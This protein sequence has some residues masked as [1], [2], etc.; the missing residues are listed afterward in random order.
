MAGSPSDWSAE[1][2]RARQR[3][4][5]ILRIEQAWPALL[6][7]LAWLALYAVLS[8]LDLPQRLPVWLQVPLLL[9]VL[10]AVLSLAWR[11][12]RRIAT[13]PQNA[14]DR[15]IEQ[16]SGLRH[17]PLQAL[18]D[19]PAGDAGAIGGSI[20]EAHLARVGAAIGGLRTGWPRLG[21]L[22]HDPHRLS[23]L[24]GPALLAALLVAGGN[25]GDRLA[26]GFLPGLF[27]PPGPMP[28]LQ[29]WVTPPDDTH[30][31][32]VFLAEARADVTVPAGSVLQLSLTGVLGHPRLALRALDPNPAPPEPAS[33]V[34]FDRLAAGSWALHH[35]L[36]AG[37]RL[38][39]RANGR[40]LADWTL[41]VAPP[42][43]I[44]VAW[45]GTPGPAS[46]PWL[47][48]LPWHVA[49]PYGVSTLAAE[50]R[51]ADPKAA[52]IA[53]LRVPIPL[54]PDARNASGTALPDLA[55][56]PRAGE[57]VV[58]T[59][60]ATDATGRTALSGEAR[61]R[62]PQRPF[63]NPLARAVLDARKRLALGRETRA[64]TAS[65]LQALG[66][67]PGA[68]AT[69]PG[70][71]LN[72]SSAAS[73]LRDDDVPDDAAIVEATARLWDLALALEDGLHN[74][75]AGARA[76]SDVRAARDALAQQLEHMRQLG[77]KGQIA[78]EQSELERRIQALTAA[79]G[80]RLQAL[81]EQAKREHSMLPPMP[82][83]HALT[84]GDLAR[85]LQ[86]MRDAASAG[87][88]QEAMQQLQR[89]QSMLDRMRSATP[90]DLQSLREQAQAQAQVREQ[91]AGLHDLERREGDLLDQSQARQGA[92]QR[93]AQARSGADQRGQMDEA[94]AEL[95]S[96]LGVSPPQEQGFPPPNP[97]GRDPDAPDPQAEAKRQKADQA[98]EQARAAQ[99]ATDTRTQH[100]LSRALEELGQEFKGLS[101]KQPGGFNEAG[102]AMQSARE[103]LAAGQDQAAQQA[104]Q[105]AL[106]ALQKG[107]QQ[108]QQAL[109]S[110]SSGGSPMLLPGMPGSSPSED[111]GDAPGQEAQ[112]DGQDTHPGQRDPLG[113]P[114]GA[115]PHA[116]DGDTHVPDT[117]ERL[118]SRE[119]EQELRRRDTDRT[120]PPAELDYLDRLLKSF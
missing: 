11:R 117:A 17:R 79:I 24:L 76:A 27:E 48:R 34:R 44:V 109:A 73:L 32:P 70:L 41:R 36:R 35:A 106:A 85:M 50:L 8:L 72:L 7:C 75:R 65:D 64:A 49:H 2:G 26:S 22:R 19:R 90:Q 10:G 99:R 103:A 23:L 113:R 101:G 53:P 97:T 96:R 61:L 25:I 118:R 104:Q 116:D 74:D 80:R 14:I 43:Q 56:D 46:E 45:N 119:I 69:D 18:A 9:L 20:W 88:T 86:Q 33:G 63:R 4:S 57:P 120:R 71:F 51:L 13:P 5:R 114:I 81:A 100:A 68:F 102:R 93:E 91:M 29:A 107:G 28:R 82:D 42:P 38:T 105:Q 40:A 92:Q 95:L 83:A 110:S 16:R 30:A 12:L 112:G 52:G 39:L 47:T 59:L 108:M 94:T 15:R 55:A 54:P 31:A 115:G 6:H 60:L 84:G 89:M 87:H 111:P 77:D 1:A 66:E 62:L 78:H 98:A 3:A 37:T 21:L 67:A 58:A